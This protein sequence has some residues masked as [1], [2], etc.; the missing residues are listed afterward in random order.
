MLNLKYTLTKKLLANVTQ[1][2]RLYGQI[3][4]MQIP[5]EIEL[6]LERDNKIKSSYF[7]NSI[8]GNPLSLPEVTNL[9]LDERMPINRDEK[10]VFNYFKI[11]QNLENFLQKD[12]NLDLILEIHKSLMNG[13]NDKIAG[14]IRDKAIVVGKYK[15]ESGKVMIDIK[16]NPPTHKRS[17]INEQLNK[18]NDWINENAE[19]P[20]IIKAGIFHHHFVYIHP[21]EDGNGRTCR[22][23][24][25]LLFLKEN[26]FINKYFVLDDYYDVDKHLYSDSLHSADIGDKTKWLEYFSDGVKFSLQSAQSRIKKS[27]LT[28][29]VER[30]PSNKEKEV[31]I[32]LQEYPEMTSTDIAKKLQVSRQQSHKLLSSLHKKG[33][34]EKIGETKASY[35]KLR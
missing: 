1:F 23:I 33:L 32:L 25:A 20:I 14:Q 28:L 17:E 31:I 34:I 4:G 8:E 5:K 15:T 9:L 21:F 24:T 18:L 27:L 19:L 10:E 6:N 29:K 30:R 35:Y 7:S 3:E 2:E 12:L 26:Y 11:L 16:H 13:V 22:L